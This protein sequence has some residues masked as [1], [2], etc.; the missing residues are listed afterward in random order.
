[1]NKVPLEVVEQI[2]DHIPSG[3]HHLNGSIHPGS[4]DCLRAASMVCS[5]FR[6]PCQKKMLSTI[7]LESQCNKPRA[8]HYPSQRLWHLFQLS[9][10]LASYVRAIHIRDDECCGGRTFWLDEDEDLPKVLRLVAQQNSVRY[11]ALDLCRR[12]Q[13]QR[14]ARDAI[15]AICC[16]ESLTCLKLTNAPICIVD[17]C[18]PSLKELEIK[19]ATAQCWEQPFKTPSKG[20][21]KLLN[22]LSISD[23]FNHGSDS[24]ITHLL[25]RSSVGQLCEV[26]KLG[27]Q[28]TRDG[29][30]FSRELLHRFLVDCACSLEHLTVDVLF[31]TVAD[32]PQSSTLADISVF[33]H[34]SRLN[35]VIRDPPSRA[36]NPTS[37]AALCPLLTFSLG[38]IQLDT[39][40]IVVK[41]EKDTTRGQWPAYWRKLDGTL[42]NRLRFPNLKNISIKIQQCM[43]DRPRDYREEVEPYLPK[44]RKEGILRFSP[45]EGPG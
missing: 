35:L 39:I 2:I 16:T 9:P 29:P 32:G 38:H 33:A 41:E 8:S 22:C 34:M 14:E 7:Y 19:H 21:L 28:V 42:S 4:L 10:K 25:E 12:S 37:S 5:A 31:D 43:Q 27:I 1:M 45:V 13:I 11:L 30:P 26:R 24:V 17:W 18:G 6:V 20:S 36:A 15:F 40:C 44:L 23:P 3:S